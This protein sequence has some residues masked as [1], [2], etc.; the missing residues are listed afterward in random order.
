MIRPKS[1]AVPDTAHA[2]HRPST[3]LRFALHVFR[4]AGAAE[5]G[6]SAVFTNVQELA[7][8]G[9]LETHATEK[10][11]WA[12]AAQARVVDVDRWVVAAVLWQA[13]DAVVTAYV[14]S[15]GPPHVSCQEP[16]KTA[17][18]EG[19][20]GGSSDKRAVVLKEATSLWKE[21][22]DEAFLSV[23]G[24]SSRS[25]DQDAMPVAEKYP[26]ST[27]LS[28][29]SSAPG[30]QEQRKDILVL[31]GETREDENDTEQHRQRY[32]VLQSDSRHF[33]LA[34]MRSLA[35]AGKGGVG[36]GLAAATQAGAE[37][38]S[39]GMDLG[40]GSLKCIENILLHN[41]VIADFADGSR[42]D[43]SDIVD[44]VSVRRQ[45]VLSAAAAAAATVAAAVDGR[46][47]CRGTA[48]K[49]ANSLF[50]PSKTRDH[51]EGPLQVDGLSQG[52][53]H[54]S[55]PI[56]LSP[57]ET[58]ATRRT[59]QRAVSLS[60]GDG[61]AVSADDA[62]VGVSME[63]SLEARILVGIPVELRELFRAAALAKMAR[64][65]QQQQ[66]PQQQKEQQ[67]VRTRRKL[68]VVRHGTFT[69]H[70]KYYGC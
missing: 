38:G 58:G 15:V 43:V 13:T 69:A 12:A 67:E 47:P 30:G 28:T 57:G 63:S 65:Q 61:D 51:P 62:A 50:R 34:L 5:E 23:L 52:N 11:L 16:K 36:L 26:S 6:G 44:T 32:K 9:G 17:A 39:G 33:D 46:N 54:S 64:Q 19:L 37:A 53:R 20:E 45:R 18:A 4:T 42:L 1:T 14:R 10:S 49:D 40:N 7:G 41:F 68:A 70:R 3:T 55:L 59:I 2:L 8:M 60:E 25:G 56:E 21:L 27:A 31:A 29:P 35:L 48:K 24:Q 66:Q 22:R